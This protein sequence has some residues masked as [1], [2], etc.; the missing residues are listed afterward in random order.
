MAWVLTGVTCL[1][2]HARGFVR[3]AYLEEVTWN[4]RSNLVLSSESLNV[5]QLENDGAVF[6]SPQ[7][8]VFVLGACFTVFKWSDISVCWSLTDACLKGVLG[9]S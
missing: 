6:L 8:G 5:A 4:K 7:E 1:L 2:R 9:I 3:C